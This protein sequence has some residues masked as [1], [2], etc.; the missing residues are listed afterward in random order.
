MIKDSNAEI[1]Q[2][3][4][5]RRSVKADEMT[6]NAPSPK[7]LEDILTAAARVPD[8]GKTMPFYFIVFQGEARDEANKIIV[9][10][11]QKQNPDTSEDALQK[12]QNRF[13]RAPLVIGV[14]Y[15]M[16]RGKHPLWEQVMSTGAACQNLLLAADAHGFAA[17]WLS[18]WYAYDEEF[19]SAIGIDAR[20]TIAGFMHIGGHPEKAPADRDRPDLNEIVTYWNVGEALKKGDQYDRPKFDFPPLKMSLNS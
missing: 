1:L 9:D 7:Q 18:E 16:R 20:D 2:C 10:I 5:T 14:V 15:R 3:L 19:R 17:Q 12:E 4:L 6:A 8:H 11:Y 13:T